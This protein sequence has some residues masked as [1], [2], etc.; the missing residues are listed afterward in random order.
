MIDLFPF[1]EFPVA[2]LGLGPHGLATARA[3]HLSGAEVSAWD[4]DEARRQAA[5]E[6]EIPIV[7]LAGI[8]DWREM[9]SLVIEPDIP[10]HGPGSHGLVEAARAGQCEVIV[11]TELL[12]RAQRD[13]RYVAVVSK[14]MAGDTMDLLDHLLKV[15][16][17]EAETGG[18]PARPILDLHELELGGTYVLDMAPGRADATVSITFDAAVFLD[19]GTGPWG[20]YQTIDEILSATKWVFHRQTGPRGAVVGVDTAIGKRIAKELQ[21]RRQQVVIPVSGSSRVAGGVY[22]AGGV[23]FDDIAGRADAVMPMPEAERSSQGGR[24]LRVA[25]AYAA[26]SLLNVPPHAAMA[27]IRG[28]IDTHSELPEA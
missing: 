25:A 24:D 19:V 17:N 1:S 22:V 7:E 8:V 23:L 6:A 9:V 14:S 10:H 11:D 15:T 5:A 28:F 2:V 26:A 13:A 16:G 3:L 18:D 27:S 4:D 20:A 12:A 21:D